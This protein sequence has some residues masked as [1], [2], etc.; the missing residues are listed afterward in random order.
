MI[1][2]IALAASF[3][4]MTQ[5]SLSHPQHN[6]KQDKAAYQSVKPLKN[7]PRKSEKF[8]LQ[9][10]NLHTTADMLKDTLH[11]IS[12]KI[13]E[14][15]ST[16]GRDA[17]RE[18]LRAEYTKI[19]FQTSLQNYGSG[20]NFIA[21]KVGSDPSKVLI[22]SSHIDSVGNA[23]AND[24]G[25]GTAAALAVARA[26]ST[27]H[28]TYSLRIL[29]FDQEE[30]GLVGAKKYV[31]S[32]TQTG[33][34]L[35]DIELEMM[36][37]NGKKDGKFHVID[38]D[39]QNSTFLTQAIL[40]SIAELSLPISINKACTDRSDH[41]A[42]WKA[43]IPAVVISENFFGGDSD[44]CYHASCDILDQRIDFQYAA[45]ITDAVTLSVKKILKAE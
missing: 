27:T 44:P 15:K 10:E 16:A 31:A 37:F 19:G 13:K 29:G 45:R 17:I 1:K 33:K 32:I 7:L 40:K 2:T 14:R 38:C 34:V 12:V 39:K 11:E 43:K 5:S 6:W 23:G 26:L 28:L 22:I 9:F 4:L 3:L 18:Y 42:F 24:D 30:I 36:G 25:I 20:T 41:A 35:G 21:E 8:V